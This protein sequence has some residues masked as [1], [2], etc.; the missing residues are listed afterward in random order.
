M[1]DRQAFAGNGTIKCAI[2]GNAL[3]EHEM[4]PC[5]KA[6]VDIIYT[7]T[8]HRRPRLRKASNG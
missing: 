6:G 8:K 5:P 4:R 2:C 3:V 7:S 1:T